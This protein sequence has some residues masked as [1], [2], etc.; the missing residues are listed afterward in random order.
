[1][2]IWKGVFS[3]TLTKHVVSVR[4]VPVS[5]MKQEDFD[6][7]DYDV[8][9]PSARANLDQAILDGS[10]EGFFM[11]DVDMHKANTPHGGKARYFYPALKGESKNPD[12]SDFQSYDRFDNKVDQDLVDTTPTERLGYLLF[13]LRSLSPDEQA[14]VMERINRDLPPNYD[15]VDIDK[16]SALKARDAALLTAINLFLIGNATKA[17]K[18]LASVDILDEEVYALFNDDEPSD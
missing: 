3:P 13:M 8:L 11:V 16:F 17:R 12:P 5:E 2:S 14:Q 10:V 6:V 1:M 4:Y 18:I 15:E 7:L 9:R